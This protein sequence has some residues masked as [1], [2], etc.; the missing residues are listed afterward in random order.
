[1]WFDGCAPSSNLTRPHLAFEDGGVKAT[2]HAVRTERLDCLESTLLG[3]CAAQIEPIKHVDQLQRA[4]V[5]E[6]PLAALN[7]HG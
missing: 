6:F 3:H 4:E 2:S 1:M 7:A 5:D